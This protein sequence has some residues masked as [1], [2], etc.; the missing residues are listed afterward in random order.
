M[1]KLILLFLILFSYLFANEELEVSLS[2]KNPLMPLY[3]GSVYDDGSSFDK[4]YLEKIHEV[5]QFDFQNNAFSQVSKNEQQHEFKV[6]HFD[7]EVAFNP[8]YWKEKKIA[9]VVKL[10][11]KEKY[12]K[13]YVYYVEKNSLR[14]FY[15]I[16]L[17]GDLAVDRIKIHN[18]CDTIQEVLFGKK[19]I[20]SS[21]IIYTI[22]ID[23]P[24]KT[25]H[26]KWLS[27]VWLCDYDGANAKQLTF[28]NSYSVHPIFIPEKN[29][30]STNF[31]Y[32]S[33]KL[34]QPKIYKKSLNSPES[35]RLVSL[36]GNQLLPSISN[37][38]KQLAFICDAAGRPDLFMQLFD[39]NG[40]TQG[41]PVQLYSAAKATQA[42][43][44]FSP[45]NKKL[46]FVSD[47]DG[48]PRIYVIKIPE[49]SY[50][51]M[52]P[53]AQLITKKNKQ[54][55]T[56]GWSPDGTKLVY[57]AKTEGTRQLWVYDFETNEEWQL[58]KDNKNKE[59]PYWAPD[60]LHI[61]YNTEDASTSEIY[62]ININQKE[63]AKISKGPA[64]ERFP[65]WEPY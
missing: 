61:V 13:T 55:V 6:S 39:E 4:P 10:V 34:G 42:S 25:G 16:F 59:N 58:T 50:N 18:L 44:T 38:A 14:T 29:K 52:R 48:T 45:D 20:A 28:E 60:S 57:S 51:R 49:K 33:Y 62:I 43:P 3:V 19:G 1:K 64:K 65:S 15:D 46:A 21:K 23:N 7:N 32:V 22:R 56:P 41:K 37:N 35:T 24:D 9:Y 47:K 17:C 31:L 8:E 63:A 11:A 36:R 30:K 5:F 2:T 40:L 54:N 12:L 53:V 27:E 26:L